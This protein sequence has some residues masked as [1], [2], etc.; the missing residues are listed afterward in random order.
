MEQRFSVQTL[1]SQWSIYSPLDSSW[2]HS[3]TEDLGVGG[4]V[5]I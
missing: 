3:P 2:F 4:G 1:E 5:K